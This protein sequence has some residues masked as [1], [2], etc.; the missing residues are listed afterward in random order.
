M[1]SRKGWSAPSPDAQT[2]AVARLTRGAPQV[3]W[4]LTDASGI[5]APTW[6]AP[7]FPSLVGEVNS[8]LLD[9]LK[10]IVKGFASDQQ[11]GADD[12]DCV[13]GAGK[14]V[15][16]VDGRGHSH[17]LM[18]FMAASTDPFL[19]LVLGFGTAY[20]PARRWSFWP[21]PFRSTS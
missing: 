15:R 21:P 7:N 18:T 4:A 8:S 5:A 3:G 10:A 19:S 16:P 11:V 13:A 12:L 14:L 9:Q 2:A 1:A 6:V 20:P 17:P